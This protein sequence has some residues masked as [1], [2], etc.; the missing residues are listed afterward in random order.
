MPRNVNMSG[1]RT[2]F[3]ASRTMPT[4]V[5]VRDA[6]ADSP[7]DAPPAS[8]G[9]RSRRN[10]CPTAL[11]SGQRTREIVS[12]TT[13][14]PASAVRSVSV[15]PRPLTISMSRRS[16]YSGDTGIVPT[17]TRRP[18]GAVAL[19]KAAVSATNSDGNDE[20][21][22]ATTDGSPTVSYTHL[23]AHETP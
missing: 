7:G 9:G 3:P 17:V 14:T 11:R 4:T 10:T 12:D 8:D 6:I 20:A 23:R 13:T 21:A 2:P 15:K 19:A 22:T 16:K 5:N 1:N 18:L